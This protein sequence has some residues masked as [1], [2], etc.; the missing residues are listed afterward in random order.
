MVI[1]RVEANG[2]DF[3]YLEDGSGPLVLLLHGFPDTA[4]TWDDVRGRLAAKGY[5]AVSPFMRGY[6]PTAIPSR[7]PDQETL[8]RDVIGLMAAAVRDPDP[9]IFFEH[10]SLYATKGE[11]PDGEIVDPSQ[12][13]ATIQEIMAVECFK[14]RKAITAVSCQAAIIRTIKFP[15]MAFL[16][17]FDF[18]RDFRGAPLAA[19]VSRR[20]RR[21]TPA[22]ARSGKLRPRR[23]TGGIIPP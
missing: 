23:S 18:E 3:A 1:H 15:P 12:V 19:V 11:V 13:A 21:R 7:D 2:L 8:A 4:H 20:D 22:A 9:V 10:K 5:R 16:R 14:C 17:P 6:R